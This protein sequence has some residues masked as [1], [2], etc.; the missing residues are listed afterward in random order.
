MWIVDV[1]TAQARVL[2]GISLNGIF[3]SPCEWMSNSESLV[4]KTV[5]K[6]GGPAP[7]R[8]AVPTGPVVQENLGRATPGPTYEDLLKSPED[9]RVFDYYATS[10]LEIVQIAATNKND[11]TKAVGDPGVIESASPSPDGRYILVDERHHP[12]SYLLPY[13]MFP[14]RERIVNLATGASKQLVDKPLED[15]IPNIHDAV[16]AGPREFGWR[17][18][19]PATVFWV[20]AGDGG[21]PRRN[22]STRDA[23]FLLDAPFEGSSRKLADLPVRF[24]SVT[25][26]TGGLAL[27]EERR[28]KDRKRIMLAIA[29]QAATSAVTLFEGSFEDRYHD[30][31]EPFTTMN[32][33]GKDVLQTNSDESGIYLHSRGASP[34]GDEPFIAVMSVTNGES[35]RVWKS[36]P[37]FFET[38]VAI[39]D[40]NAPTVLI[41]HESPDVNPN[42]YIKVVGKEN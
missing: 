24:R 29:P 20:E 39:L 7:E 2:P 11:T 30:P 3:G 21:D 14:E 17:S 25:W 37:K 5:S 42:Y 15:T 22:V 38:S 41:T 10:Q 26:G 31:G 40:T 6:V 34:E 18:D 16:A 4:C 27:V 19:A 23:L 13:P 36:E 8:S 33:S 35:K 32:E 9:E 1:A 12:Y 28:W